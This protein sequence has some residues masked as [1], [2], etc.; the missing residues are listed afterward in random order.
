MTRMT[1][2]SAGRAEQRRAWRDRLIEG[3]FT[4]YTMLCIILVI[5]GIWLVLLD[6]KGVP[7]LLGVLVA[8]A[9]IRLLYSI[10]QELRDMN[11]RQRMG[12]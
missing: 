11:E 6:A 4:P 8:V 12:S 7:L 2:K 1:R 5:F 3:L 9:F 10:R